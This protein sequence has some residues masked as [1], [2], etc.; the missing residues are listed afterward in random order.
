MLLPVFL[1]AVEAHILSAAMQVFGMIISTQYILKHRAF[2]G[3]VCQAQYLSKVKCVSAC[4]K[5]AIELIC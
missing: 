1:L 2:S 5:R 3:E 4:R